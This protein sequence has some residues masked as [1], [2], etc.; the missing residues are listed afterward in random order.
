MYRNLVSI[1]SMFGGF[2]RCHV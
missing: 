2:V 1:W